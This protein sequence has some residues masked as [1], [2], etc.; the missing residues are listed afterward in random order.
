MASVSFLDRKKF[1]ALTSVGGNVDTDK[2]TPLIL[3]TQDIRIQ[4]VLGT[5]LYNKVKT[6]ISSGDISLAANSEY[7]TLLDDHIQPTLAH[8][9]AAELIYLTSYEVNN[10]GVV[11]RQSENSI[12]PES[13]EVVKLAQRSETKGDYYAQRMIDY[14]CAK[15]YNVFPEY[16]SFENGDVRPSRNINRT[17]WVL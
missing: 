2:I 16:N 10:T 4:D 14:I 13:F 9:T 12:V 15:G 3:S 6:L 17:G 5:P 8:Y 7:K 1:M 11:R